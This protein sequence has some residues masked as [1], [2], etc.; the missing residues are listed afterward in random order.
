MLQREVQENEQLYRMK[1]LLTKLRK[2]DM[3]VCEGSGI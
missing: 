3:K 2:M 1:K